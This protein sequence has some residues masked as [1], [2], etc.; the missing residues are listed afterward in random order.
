MFEGDNKRDA[1]D[2][3]KD[4]VEGIDSDRELKE[5]LLDS[6]GFKEWSELMGCY[7]PLDDI[8]VNEAMAQICAGRGEVSIKKTWNEMVT[9][10]ALVVW[11]LESVK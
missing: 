10:E 6:N 4:E 5:A 8:E 7:P 3:G 1:E 2:V 9:L 11:W